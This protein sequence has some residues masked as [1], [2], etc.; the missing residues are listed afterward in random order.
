MMPASGVW[1]PAIDISVVVFPQ[2][3]GPSSVTN[4]LS[5][6]VKLTSSRTRTGPN[7]LA[8]CSTRISDMS[9]AP[10]CARAQGQ[11][12]RDDDDLHD[13]QRGDPGPTTPRCQ[14]CSMVTPAISVPGFCRKTTG[15]VVAEQVTNISTN[16]ASKA[17]LSAGSSIRRAMV[18]QPAPL[19]RAARS[20]S[21]LIRIRL[22]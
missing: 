4:S 20:N 1:N 15:V 5:L 8:R 7:D 14:Y 13:G 22:G 2:P 21:V 9:N 18:H 12:D 19:A 3:D 16:A 11:H 17:G 6:T 10:D